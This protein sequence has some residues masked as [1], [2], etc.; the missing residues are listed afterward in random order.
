M[1]ARRFLITIDNVTVDM[2]HWPV[3]SES[4]R[5]RKGRG[6]AIV[7]D[8][9]SAKHADEDDGRF[10]GPEGRILFDGQH[11][12]SVHEKEHR[13]SE[14]FFRAALWS[15]MTV[16]ENGDAADGSAR[17]FDRVRAGAHAIQAALVGLAGDGKTAYRQFSTECASATGAGACARSAILFLDEPSADSTC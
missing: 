4:A 15:S 7:G 6:F 10:I 12:R 1:D 14:F 11:S 8:S 9:G 2:G 5:D 3:Q 17:L 16:L 13:R